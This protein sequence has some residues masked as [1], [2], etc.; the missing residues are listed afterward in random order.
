M[1]YYCMRIDGQIYCMNFGEYKKSGWNMDMA[2]LGKE[3]FPNSEAMKS[4][5]QIIAERNARDRN[6][7]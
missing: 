2:T 3:L 4:T 1:G 7:K 5:D 6:L